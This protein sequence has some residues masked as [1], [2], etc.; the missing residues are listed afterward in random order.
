MSLRGNLKDFS[1]ADLFRLV[2]LSRKTGAL[3]IRRSDGAEGA[4]WFRDGDVFL[5]KSDRYNEPLGQRL[6]RANGITPGGLKRALEV[7]RIEPEGGR[8]L[9][10]ILVD[11]GCITDAVLETFVRRQ[12]EETIF[13]LM[14]WDDGEFEFAAEA[15]PDSNEDIGLCVSIESVIIE[16]SRRIE[17]WSRITRKIPSTQVILRFAAMPSDRA[18]DISLTPAE[19]N[20]LRRVDGRLTVA[21][22]AA[23]MKLPEFD[24]AR[25]LYGLLETG[26][27]E[28]VFEGEAPT[29]SRWPP[30]PLVEAEDMLAD[31]TDLGPVPWAVD[32]TTLPE[33]GSAAPNGNS[34][35]A[36]QEGSDWHEPIAESSVSPEL[37]KIIDSFSHP[38]D[39]PG[40]E[41]ATGAEAESDEDWGVPDEE[42]RLSG[43]L[44]DELTGLTGAERLT[45]AP[46][47]AGRAAARGGVEKVGVD[48][49]INRATLLEIIEA[50][51]RL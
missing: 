32:E 43:V 14:I 39:A 2:S 21:Q 47:Q 38:P 31:L 7:R 19:W 44:T 34:S 22:L 3:L 26:L 18:V 8:R 46:A 25:T 36:D 30:P 1:L 51:K 11:E 16:G 48:E 24:V 15:Q 10:Q 20:V 6:V 40:P 17:E 27:V 4:V 45:K 9:G 37:A 42:L 49:R 13:D 50:V 5:A 35:C 41:E 28:F 23:V 33:T 12:I 29:A